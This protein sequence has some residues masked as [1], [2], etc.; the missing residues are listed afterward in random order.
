M[1]SLHINTPL[2]KSY[3]MSK[4]L[5]C[6]VWLKMEALQ[7]PG[8][9]KI[10]GMGY[11]ATRE[12]ERGARK[13]VSS[14]G[15]NAGLAVAYAGLQLGIPVTVYVPQNTG[16][17]AI[18]GLTLFGAEVVVSGEHWAQA[19]EAAQKELE[20]ADVAYFHPFDD[21]EV[22]KGHATMIDEVSE[23]GVAPGTVVCSVG[24][25]GLMCGV[26]AGLERNALASTRLLAVETEGAD[27]LFRSK[28]AGHIVRLPVITSNAK[29]LGAL[30]VCGRA[31]EHLANP[32]VDVCTVTD[33]EAQEACNKFLEEHRIRVELAC[34]AALAVVNRGDHAFLSEA[35]SV[36]VIVCG[37]VNP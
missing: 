35:G 29:S 7:P 5:G 34:G 13:F 2:L 4:R 16:D 12:V 23:A 15:G 6:D 9:F 32:A 20:A 19:H 1:K 10:R 21:A 18:D 22:W 14:S 37:G 33:A 36:L 30:Q 27:C 11:K 24:G 31:W 3:P 25:G 28:Q 8:S 17:S 26:I